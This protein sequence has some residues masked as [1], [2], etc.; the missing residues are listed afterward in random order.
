MLSKQ[1][2]TT[3]DIPIS[4][5]NF[6][7]DL[8]P[9]QSPPDKISVRV[10]APG[11]SIIFYNL[12]NFSILDL[13]ASASNSKPLKDGK[14][15]F[16]LMN[17][18]RKK[19]VNVLGSSM[20]ILDISPSRLSIP[21][22]NKALKR[23]PIKLQE[24]ITLKGE[25]WFSKPI[26]LLPDSV[27][28]YGHQLQLDTINHVLTK[29]LSVSNLSD[30]KKLTISLEEINGIVRK[31]TSVDVTI[32]VESFV[33]EKIMKPISVKNLKK[34]YSVKFFPENVAVT[35]RAPRDKY[36]LLQTDFFNA[37]VDATQMS[38][39]NNT[40]DV[41]INNLPSSIKLQMVYPERVEYLLIKE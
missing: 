2:E 3:M 41:L 10:K 22:K 39:E 11:F 40:L 7:S 37:E 25:Y 18:K 8:I 4:F 6:P 21:A 35:V 12:F 27:T 5:S 16:W 34:G 23:V 13:D 31:I 24:N 33:E 32:A 20:E 30:N 38:S 26:Q 14:E 29:Q 1:H 15:I 28:I 9:P 36:L 19:V 17:A